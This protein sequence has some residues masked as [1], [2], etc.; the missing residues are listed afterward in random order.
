MQN[1]ISCIHFVYGTIV[2]YCNIH[3]KD[4]VKHSNVGGK[5]SYVLST[6][7]PCVLIQKYLHVASIG[8]GLGLG[9]VVLASAS[10][11]ALAFWPR[12]TSLR[13]SCCGPISVMSQF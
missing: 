13:K 12:L 1:N 4:V 6:L 11:L 8:I 2:Y 7:S 5:F 10:A 3:Y 9:L